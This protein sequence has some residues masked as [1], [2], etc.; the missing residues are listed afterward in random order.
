MNKTAAESRVIVSL[1]LGVFALKK[2][3]IAPI[4]GVIKAR[5]M[6]IS[7]LMDGDPRGRSLLR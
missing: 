7:V 1:K 2:I 5:A 4:N 6:T 3:P